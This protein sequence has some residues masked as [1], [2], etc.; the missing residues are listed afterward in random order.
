MRIF[1]SFLVV[2]FTRKTNRLTLRKPLCE[3]H[4]IKIF[5]IIGLPQK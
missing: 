3:I 1:A 5:K 4:S 2:I